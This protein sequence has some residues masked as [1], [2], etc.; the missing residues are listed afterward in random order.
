MN[1]ILTV[2]AFM[3]AIS[4]CNK[5]EGNGRLDP[6]SMLVI[7]A[8]VDVK[9]DNPEH[10]TAREV[11]EY[12]NAISSF[13]YFH[14]SETVLYSQKDFERNRILMLSSEII[15][16][17]TLVTWRIEDRDIV[18]LRI[19]VKFAYLDN[20]ICYYPTPRFVPDVENKKIN[21][22]VYGHPKDEN[23]KYDLDKSILVKRDE[24]PYPP[25]FEAREDVYNA[26]LFEYGEILRKDTCAYIPNAVMI[27]AEKN[28]KAAYARGDYAACYKLFDTAL[29]F[30]PITGA[31]WRALKA[32]GIE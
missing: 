13:T 17:D 26:L 3:A 16:A 11:V 29:T 7:N 5:E 25:G 4:S 6:N 30:Y 28:I 9:G 20:K 18:I 23:G 1:K 31:E 14:G 27:E 12:A 10:C 24:Y 8:G 2:I 19:G 15:D 21:V 32:Q 22:C